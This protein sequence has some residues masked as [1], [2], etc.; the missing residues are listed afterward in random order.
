MYLKKCARFLG[1]I[2]GCVFDMLRRV[3]YLILYVFLILFF[4]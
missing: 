3:Q 1:I 4:F 2:K